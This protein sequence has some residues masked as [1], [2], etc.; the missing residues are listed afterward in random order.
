[1]LSS[2]LEFQLRLNEYKTE[3]HN[4]GLVIRT[5]SDVEKQIGRGRCC[6]EVVSSKEYCNVPSQAASTQ[7]K[8]Q[9]IFV[10]TLARAR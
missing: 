10:D 8:R 9:C 3:A 1:M 4:L 6:V 5:L 2:E 7:R